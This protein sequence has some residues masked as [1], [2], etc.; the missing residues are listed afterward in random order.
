MSFLVFA[1]IFDASIINTAREGTF[2]DPD[3]F[4][5]WV[6]NIGNDGHAIEPDG[7]TTVNQ[8]RQML[9]ENN[10]KCPVLLFFLHPSVPSS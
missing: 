8:F 7:M 2:K 6:H 5:A 10:V 1:R 3:T 4:V 9:K